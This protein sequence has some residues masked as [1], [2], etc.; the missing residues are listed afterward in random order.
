[1]NDKYLE[2]IFYG[3][4]LFSKS[5]KEGSFPEW[6]GTTYLSTKLTQDRIPLL[7]FC[8]NYIRWHELD[9]DMIEP[10]LVAYDEY[11]MTISPNDADL[12][13]LFNIGA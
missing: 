10:A 12:E 7:R 13:V 6:E 4:V 5:I 1:M 11:K 3:I 8:Y 9:L 2:L